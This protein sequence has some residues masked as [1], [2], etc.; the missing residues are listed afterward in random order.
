MCEDI[1]EYSKML[2]EK[3]TCDFPI[4]SAEQ[5]IISRILVEL[6]CQNEDSDCLRECPK[7]EIVRDRH[8]HIYPTLKGSQYFH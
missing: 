6:Y 2:I 4:G 7:K 3:N 8:T 5:I 1:T